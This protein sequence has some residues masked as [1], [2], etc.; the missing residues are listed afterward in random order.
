[1][2][3]IIQ[4]LETILE[5]RKISDS[6]DSYVSSLYEKGNKY[7]C[8]KILEECQELVEATHENK[9]QLIHETADLLFHVLVLLASHDIKYA[10]IL[11]ELERRFGTSG[12]EEKNNRNK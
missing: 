11:D 1:M 4:K 9:E 10:R 5:Q 12:I 3:S 7:I 2:D 8:D 6:K